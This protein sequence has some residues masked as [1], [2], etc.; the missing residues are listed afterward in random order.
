ML[1]ALVPYPLPQFHHETTLALLGYGLPFLFFFV[2][3]FRM[4][5]LG[6]KTRFS[7]Q[8]LV[9]YA[10]TIGLCV[11]V[12][13]ALGES[14]DQRWLPS[15]VFGP[16]GPWKALGVCCLWLGS[17]HL[18]ADQCLRKGNEVSQRPAR[19]DR[20]FRV[21]VVAILLCCGGCSVSMFFLFYLMLHWIY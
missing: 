13:I 11:A 9:L 6:W 3:L 18:W 4:K 21:S 5:I 2:G 17:S 19:G 16:M 14:L 8:T 15:P 1:I 12:H 20:D 7:L 10:F